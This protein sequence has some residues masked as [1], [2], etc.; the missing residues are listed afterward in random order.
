MRRYEN[1]CILF[2]VLFA[3]FLSIFEF[4]YGV[5]NMYVW[6]SVD[7][8]GLNLLLCIAFFCS[9]APVEFYSFYKTICLPLP[10]PLC[11]S[12]YYTLYFFYCDAVIFRSNADIF[13]IVVVVAILFDR[14][15]HSFC[16]PISYSHYLSLYFFTGYD[17]WR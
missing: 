13:V 9:L 4:V 2:I 12:P 16:C 11:F 8:V 1:A 14:V 17:V 6:G 10:L 5:R 7:L 15:P 3:F